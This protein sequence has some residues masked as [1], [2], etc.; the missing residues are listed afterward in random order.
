VV[1]SAAVSPAEVDEVVRL[2]SRELERRERELRG[3]RPAPTV[4][5]RTVVLVDDGVATGSTMRAA[6]AALRA[7]AAKRIVVAVP[8]AAPENARELAGEVQEF[9][10]VAAPVDFAAISRWYDDF[11]QTTDQEVREIVERAAGGAPSDDP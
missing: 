2:E 8:V 9:V 1:E 5:G 6:I 11:S 7:L 10:C 4:A 3:E